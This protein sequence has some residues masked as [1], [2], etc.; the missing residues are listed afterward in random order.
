MQCRRFTAISGPC[1]SPRICLVIDDIS[2]VRA[3]MLNCIDGF[4]R[5]N[6]RKPSFPFGGV[7]IILVGDIC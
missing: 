3:D 1:T 6:G 7:Q 5:L 2:M 4:L